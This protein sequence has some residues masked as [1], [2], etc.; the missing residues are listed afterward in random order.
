MLGGLCP[1]VFE[2][3]HRVV[4]AKTVADAVPLWLDTPTVD[5]VL[6]DGAIPRATPV[7]VSRRC[8]R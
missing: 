8:G 2:E 1:K 7:M 3:P 6:L 5:V 4:Q